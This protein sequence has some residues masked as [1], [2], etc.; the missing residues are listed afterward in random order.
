[1]GG[2]GG[3]TAL[4]S[5]HNDTKGAEKRSMKFKKKKKKKFNPLHARLERKCYEENKQREEIVFFPL[6]GFWPGERELY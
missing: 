6:L 3:K 2:G 1:M 5:F 4:Y